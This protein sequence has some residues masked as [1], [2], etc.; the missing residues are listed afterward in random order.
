MSHLSYLFFLKL[1]GN[2]EVSKRVF[3]E[4]EVPHGQRESFPELEKFKLVCSPF[5]INNIFHSST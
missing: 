5:H 4:Y 3:V 1:H 2:V